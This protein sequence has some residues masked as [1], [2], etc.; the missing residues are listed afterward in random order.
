[1][2]SEEARLVMVWCWIDV[3]ESKDEALGPSDSGP[4]KVES[5][6]IKVTGSLH[7]PAREARATRT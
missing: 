7:I 1:M 2:M 6:L 3:G 4:I 5:A